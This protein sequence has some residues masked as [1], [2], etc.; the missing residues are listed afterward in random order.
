MIETI[1]IAEHVSERG[2]KILTRGISSDFDYL[3]LSLSDIAFSHLYYA[4]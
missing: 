1:Q 4:Q 2:R 3:S